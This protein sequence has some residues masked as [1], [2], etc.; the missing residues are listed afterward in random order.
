M[1]LYL[2]FSNV[3]VC[4]FP[5]S[6]PA[7][8]VQIQW[9]WTP[10]L[11]PVVNYEMKILLELMVTWSMLRILTL[12]LLLWS[13]PKWWQRYAMDDAVKICVALLVSVVSHS[14]SCYTGLW[15][16]LKRGTTGWTH[17]WREFR[18]EFG[19]NF[20]LFAIFLLHFLFFW[21]PFYDVFKS[22]YHFY[23]S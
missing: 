23:S 21:L 22:V 5:L 1:D 13:W 18:W 10:F 14:F 16:R 11:F 4:F 17:D 6:L 20:F 9:D 2:F 3:F 7:S 8:H 19:F 15:K 12:K